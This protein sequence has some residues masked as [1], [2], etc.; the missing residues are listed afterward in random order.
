MANKISSNGDDSIGSA[1]SGNQGGG[2]TGYGSQ[3]RGGVHKRNDGFRLG[4]PFKG[5]QASGARGFAKSDTGRG[6][7]GD[8]TGGKASY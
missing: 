7:G 3:D 2:Q 8:G 1:Y 5:R 6:H 4:S